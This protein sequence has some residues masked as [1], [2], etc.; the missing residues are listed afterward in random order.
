MTEF[1]E[2][3]RYEESKKNKNE[4]NDSQLIL[5]NFGKDLTLLAEE[6]KLDN[7]IG[8]D[9][10]IN[11][12][13]QILSRR[14]KNNPLLLGE[15]GCGKTAIVEGLAIK[16]A[17]GECPSSLEGKRI[18]S[19]DLSSLVAGTK[20]RGQFEE[21]I[22]IIVDELKENSNIILFIDEIHTM[23]GAGNSSGSLDVSNI[24]KPALSRGEIH[25]IGATTLNEYHERIERDGALDRRFQKVYIN[26]PNKE[27]TFEII[28]KSKHSYEKYHSVYFSDEILKLCVDLSDR[29]INYREFPDK[30]F[31]L[32]D[33]IGSRAKI[34]IEY[35]KKI[36]DLKEESKQIK[37][38]KRFM[39]EQEDYEAAAE[40]RNREKELI[41][42]FKAEKKS[43]DDNLKNQ[44]TVIKS[45]HVYSVISEIAKV[46]LNNLNVTVGDKLLDLEKNISK[47]VIG[48]MEAITLI[49]KAIRRNKVGIRDENRPIG[50]FI[51]IGN[52]GMGKTYLAKQIAKQIFGSENNLIRF[53]M[54]EYQER[55]NSSKLIGAPPGYIGYEKGGLLTEQV[56][57]NPYSVILFDEVEKADKEILS[58]L[59]KI[60]DEGAI[61]DSLGRKIDFT[62]SLIILTSNLGAKKIQDFGRGIGF[63]SENNENKKNEI[64]EKEL[65]SFFAPEFLNRIDEIIVFNKLSKD[66]I[67]EIINIEI[68]DL[69]KRLKKKNF[70]ID[71]DESAISEIL[72]KG[73][74]EE[75]GARPIKR[76]IQ[77]FIED[78]IS[79][80]ILR[81][82]IKENK[83]YKLVF[84]ED[85]LII[86]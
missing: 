9:N 27:E 32:L 40:L 53:D 45:E 70:N 57:N 52:T 34:M 20:Y 56:K 12:I 63:G 22:K 41:M 65:K 39:V 84:K 11:R 5:L 36:R 44:K 38:K 71:L 42:E 59:L 83:K 37:E 58:I 28:K 7:V 43:F 81:K 15:P 50:N 2:P 80:S 74:D 14:K 67:R 54:S 68:K 75:M 61:T 77:N 51:F 10:E 18:I 16:I 66:N 76:V 78:F 33:E 26:S 47:S 82:K 23:V 30:A 48:Q 69:Q 60:L 49:S 3:K 55:H 46:P 73:Y 35:P 86:S 1:D 6:E 8:R 31:D 64:I 72:N 62:N 21:R 19:L 25:C 4:R 29:Y 85:K 79:E 13:A 17:Q 24:F